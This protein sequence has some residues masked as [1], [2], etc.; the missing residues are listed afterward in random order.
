MILFPVARATTLPHAPGTRYSN[1]AVYDEATDRVVHGW[2]VF[3]QKDADGKPTG[4][5][6]FVDND[7]MLCGLGVARVRRDEAA[8]RN[9]HNLAGALRKLYDCMSAQNDPDQAKRPTEEDLAL[10][11]DY[12]ERVLLMVEGIQGH[13]APTAEQLEAARNAGILRE[14]VRGGA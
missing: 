5:E 10:A 2:Q 13:A 8:A 12:A 1:S 9:A 6:S 4:R 7:G 14:Q 3:I 11:M